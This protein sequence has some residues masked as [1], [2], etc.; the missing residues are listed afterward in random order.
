VVVLDNLS[1]GHLDAVSEGAQWVQGRIQDAGDVL[2]GD[3]S[4]G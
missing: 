2:M 1:T 3:S 4:M